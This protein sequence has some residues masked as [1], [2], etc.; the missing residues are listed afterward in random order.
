MIYEALV[1][2][3][4]EDIE[5]EVML[6]IDDI[7]LAGFASVCP[8]NIEVGLSYPVELHPVVFDDYSVNALPDGTLPSIDRVGTGFAYVITGKLSGSCLESGGLVIEDE[9]LQ[10]NFSYLEGKMVAMKI[11]RMDVEFL[12]R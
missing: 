6:R 3:V 1:L 5:E 10:R 8:Y 2:C 7:E 9:M 4:D 11:D 12:S